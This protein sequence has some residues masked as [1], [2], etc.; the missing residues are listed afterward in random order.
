MHPAA[1]SPNSP[2]RAN[3]AAVSRSLSAGSGCAAASSTRCAMPGTR[4]RYMPGATFSNGGACGRSKRTADSKRWAARRR[5][6]TRRRS[7]IP[8]TLTIPPSPP[9]SGLSFPSSASSAAKARVAFTQNSPPI[10]SSLGTGAA[11]ST[12]PACSASRCPGAMISAATRALSAGDKEDSRTRMV[13]F[14]QGEYF[15]KG[16][17]RMTDLAEA[18]ASV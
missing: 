1:S 10:M 12:Y 11:V 17:T 9:L 16:K 15:V 7:G 13:V 6:R 3:S 14:P 4:T 2:K 8:D 18:Q 5:T